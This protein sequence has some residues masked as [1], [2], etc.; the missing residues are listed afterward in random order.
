MDIGPLT[1]PSLAQTLQEARSWNSAK[2]AGLTLSRIASDEAL[3]TLALGTQSG[4]V[5]TIK[6]SVLCLPLWY[7]WSKDKGWTDNEGPEWFPDALNAEQRAFLKKTLT[8]ALKNLDLRHAAEP[9][10][11]ETRRLILRQLDQLGNSTP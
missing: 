2:N 5:L 9:E 8:Q 3:Q 6:A 10:Y 7:E 1:I 11:P 4:K